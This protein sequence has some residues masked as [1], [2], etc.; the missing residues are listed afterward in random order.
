MLHLVTFRHFSYFFQPCSG[1]GCS[2]QVAD[3][4]A[5]PIPALPAEQAGPLW[6]RRCGQ[7]RM[8]MMDSHHNNN[9]NNTTFGSTPQKDR[10][11]F[12]G[13]YRWWIIPLFSRDPTIGQSVNQEDLDSDIQPGQW[14]AGVVEMAIE[15]YQ[16]YPWNLPFR[17]WQDS[18]Y[19]LKEFA[20]L[21][22]STVHIHNYLVWRNDK[23]IGDSTIC[24]RCAYIDRDCTHSTKSKLTPGVI[25]CTCWVRF[26]GKTCCAPGSFLSPGGECCITEADDDA[27]DQG[28]PFF[29]VRGVTANIWWH[30][31]EKSHGKWR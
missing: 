13:C 24:W 8:G 11:V 16:L 17:N 4:E 15:L 18:G 6:G 20:L 12:P 29:W 27:G 31:H 9:N 3:S 23:R 21:V 2:G 19:L 22:L 14:D 10:R 5:D 25:G 26:M 28:A 30:R 1:Q 7:A